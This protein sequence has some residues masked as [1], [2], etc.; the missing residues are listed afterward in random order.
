MNNTD[1]ELL[2][3]YNTGWQDCPEGIDNSDL[4]DNDFLKRAYQIGWDFYIMGDD[5]PSLD[6]VTPEEIITRIKNYA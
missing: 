4:Y 5:N 1:Q 6:Y 2:D 3:A